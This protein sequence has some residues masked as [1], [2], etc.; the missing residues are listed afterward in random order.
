MSTTRTDHCL[1]C[2]TLAQQSRPDEYN[3]KQLRVECPR[4]GTYR[5]SERMHHE[6]VSLLHRIRETGMNPPLL[7]NVEDMSALIRE[8]YDANDGEDVY[9]EDWAEFWSE[10]NQRAGA[11]LHRRFT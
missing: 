8:R 6:M 7:P 2:G 9:L 1:V 10:T 5:L 11:R 3:N 4:C